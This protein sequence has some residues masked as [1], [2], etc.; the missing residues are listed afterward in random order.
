VPPKVLFLHGNGE[1]YLS[2]SLLHGLRAV[3][4]EGLVDVPRRDAMYD[5]LPAERRARLYGRGFTL[6]GRLPEIGLDR[7]RPIER[8]LDGEF[9]LVILADIHRNWGPWVRLRPELGRLRA[10]GTTIAVVDGGDSAVMYPFGPTWWRRMRP[11]PLPRAHGRVPY[12]KRELQP[13]TARVRHYGLVPGRLGLRW[14]SRSVRPIAFSIPEEHLT[15]G[16]DPK[17]KL[18]AT[19]VVDPEVA[20]LTPDAS[21]A[22][23]FDSE[24][25]YFADLRASRFGVTTKKAGWDCMRHYELAASGC[26]PCFRDL[27]AKPSL[28]APHGL[29]AS[30]CVPY[31]DARELLDRVGSMGDAEYDRLREGALRWARANTTRARALELLEGLGQSRAA[32][33]RST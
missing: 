32:P 14:L 2:D 29:D 7:S 28:T 20:E 31:T 19:H 17:T 1:D 25:E 4:G 12:F 24:E 26:V 18:L 30:N 22:Y 5:D 15:G 8:A 10:K 13:M 21:S 27:D 23:A 9:D 16:D 33:A 6:W 3:L 11:W